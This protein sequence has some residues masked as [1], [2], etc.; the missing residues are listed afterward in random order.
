[1]LGEKIV[2]I[3]RK[4]GLSRVGM[5]NRLKMQGV[6]VTPQILYLLENGVFEEQLLAAI[7]RVAQ[8][9]ERNRNLR[10]VIG[11]PAYV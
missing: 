2:D 5:A 6:T 9:E 8:S 4:C 3:R 11:E 1:M 7:E 10:E